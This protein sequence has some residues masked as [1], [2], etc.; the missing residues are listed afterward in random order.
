MEIPSTTPLTN[1]EQPLVSSANNNKYTSIS[2]EPHPNIHRDLERFQNQVNAREGSHFCQEFTFERKG[3]LVL[4]FFV[5]L[6]VIGVLLLKNCEGCDP[7]EAKNTGITLVTIG[8]CLT[9]AYVAIYAFSA[10]RSN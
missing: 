9:A 5:T 8:S 2:T 1:E 4:A 10:L 6:A 7:Q 3:I